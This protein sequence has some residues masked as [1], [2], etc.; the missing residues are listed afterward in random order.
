MNR[1][2]LRTHD[3]VKSPTR[4]EN[5]R[6]DEQFYEQDDPAE[7]SPEADLPKNDLV[8]LWN[9]FVPFRSEMSVGIAQF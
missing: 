5:R 9:C 8:D 6:E 4:V 7:P 1:R 3:L 2:V